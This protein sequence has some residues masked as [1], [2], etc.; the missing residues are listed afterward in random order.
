MKAARKLRFE[1]WSRLR[2]LP[3]CLCRC[4]VSRLRRLTCALAC[5][6]P[7]SA[8]AFC[9]ADRESKSSIISSAKSSV[10]HARILDVWSFRL[11]AIV[12]APGSSPAL[13]VIFL[14]I[15]R[16]VFLR[17]PGVLLL[18]GRNG[19]VLPARARW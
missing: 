2:R 13:Q 12:R 5:V 11:R 8:Q 3:P 1:L 16:R 6:E 10:L 14:Q 19:F 7:E 4:E 17:T 9:R 15:G 18:R